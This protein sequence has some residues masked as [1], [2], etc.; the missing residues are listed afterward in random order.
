MKYHIL[1]QIG[2]SA[3]FQ[4]L[5]IADGKKHLKLILDGFKTCYP[6]YKM[7]IVIGQDKISRKYNNQ[8]KP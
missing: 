3:K 4:H 5:T 8:L 6:K 7:W 1:R 2:N